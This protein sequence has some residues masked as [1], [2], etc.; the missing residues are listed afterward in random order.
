MYEL[1]YSSVSPSGFSESELEGILQKARSKNEGLGITG[2][3]VYHD[4]EIMQILEGDE[5]VI[6]D[7]YTTISQ[8]IRHRS[9]EIL[10]QGTIEQRSFTQW[11]MAFKLLDQES[12]QELVLGL[13]EYDLKKTPISMIKES[14]NRGKKTFLRMRDML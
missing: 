7:L 14:Q 6:R 4:R 11:T 12:A 10:Y 9:V 2:M 3:L 5:K 8:D 1:L 13:E